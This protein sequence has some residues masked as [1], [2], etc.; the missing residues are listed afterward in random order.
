MPRDIPIALQS[1]LDT[2]ATSLAQ[3]LWIQPKVGAVIGLTNT[4]ADIVYDGVTYSSLSGFEDSAYQ[5][6]A[7][8]EIDNAEAKIVFPPVGLIGITE[9][10]A[11]A[12]Y[13]DGARFRVLLVDYNNLSAGHAILDWGFV[14]QVRLRDSSA[15]VIELRGAQQMTRQKAV[16]ERGSKTCRATFGDASTGCGFDLTASGVVNYGTISAVGAEPDRMFTSDA[17]LPVPG[18]VTFTTGDNAGLSFEVETAGLISSFMFPAP[19]VIQIGDEFTWREDCDKRWETCKAKGQ[20]LNFRGEPHRPEAIG[21]A[22]QFPGAAT[23]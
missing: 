5:V 2:R 13:L 15:S 14:G 16:C 22:L 9:D 3:L 20:K 21:A 8:S 6:S 10:Q 12:G 18:L 4:N 23:R 17:D 19:F 7:G 1:A 11:R